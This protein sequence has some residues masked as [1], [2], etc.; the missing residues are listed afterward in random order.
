MGSIHVH[1]VTLTV[2]NIQYLCQPKAYLGHA[3][4]C[5]RLI[6]DSASIREVYVMLALL[7]L[8]V[9]YLILY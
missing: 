4:L 5:S 9:L 3:G 7:G 2:F 1:W 8:S 6:T